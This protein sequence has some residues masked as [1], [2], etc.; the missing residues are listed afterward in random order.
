MARRDGCTPLPEPPESP[1]E[2]YPRARLDLAQYE[3]ST[4]TGPCFVC[5]VVAGTHPEPHY[6]VHRDEEHVAFLDR[7]PTLY[8]YLLVSPVEH[9]EGLVEDL[10][11]A[12]YLRLQSLVY[13]LGRA[14]SAIVPT[15]RLYVLSLGSKQGNAHLHWH[16][17]PLPP[18]VPYGEQ[19][20]E[21]LRTETKGYLLIDPEDQ[22]ELARKIAAALS[23]PATPP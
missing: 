15:E 4:R 7:F 19:Q 23:G 20:Y 21:A 22:A 13:R 2:R 6:I 9:R 11:E 12:E 18:G 17:A 14:V 8:G 1:G 10:T 5:Q 3:H 16:L